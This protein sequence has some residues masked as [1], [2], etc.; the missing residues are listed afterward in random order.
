MK[1]T[2]LAKELLNLMGMLSFYVKKIFLK[3]R[4]LEQGM[5][6][7]NHLGE[8]FPIVRHLHKS[9]WRS[10]RRGFCW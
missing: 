10:V 3:F 8:E 2:L 7:N 1:G 4:L 6:I 5:G 9:H